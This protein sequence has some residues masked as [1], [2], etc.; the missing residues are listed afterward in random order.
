[1]RAKINQVM[2]GVGMSK[3]D[4]F[5]QLLSYTKPL[6]SP[7]DVIL[8]IISIGFDWIRLKDTQDDDMS[9]F[10]GSMMT[11]IQIEKKV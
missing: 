10:V 9:T 3:K 5:L 1:M 7:L 2:T 8:R 11:S 4:Y 6:W